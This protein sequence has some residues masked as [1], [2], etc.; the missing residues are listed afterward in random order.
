MPG[1]DWRGKALR[2]MARLGLFT[3][4]TGLETDLFSVAT[5]MGLEWLGGE[6]RCLAWNGEGFTASSAFIECVWQ[7]RGTARMGNV[8]RGQALRGKARQ[9]KGWQQR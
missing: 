6:W 8:R 4:S 9:G 5:P 3:A 2:G 1:K 7:C